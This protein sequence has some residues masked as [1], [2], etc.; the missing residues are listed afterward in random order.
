[1]RII[2]NDD[3]SNENGAD[4]FSEENITDIDETEVTE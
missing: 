1:M 3:I 4:N 2:E